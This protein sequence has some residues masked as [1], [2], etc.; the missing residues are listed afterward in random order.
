MWRCKSFLCLWASCVRFLDGADGE[1][2]ANGDGDTNAINRVRTFSPDKSVSAMDAIDWVRTF[3]PDKS[4]GGYGCGNS[5]PDNVR[6]PFIASLEVLIACI[7]A[8]ACS[9]I[10]ALA[11]S[12]AC[13]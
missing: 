2:S 4:G 6:T 8:L 13:S 5:L 11:C 9:C 7:C 3:S 10:C 12:W 1:A